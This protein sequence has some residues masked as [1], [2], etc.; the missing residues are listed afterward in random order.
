MAYVGMTYIGMAYVR[1]AYEVVAC[2]RINPQVQKALSPYVLDWNGLYRNGLYR[3]GLCYLWPMKI[4]PAYSLI[5][6][7]RRTCIVMAY[8]VLAYIVMAYMGMAHRGMAYLLMAHVLP[9]DEVM[10]YVLINP[11]V[12]KDL[13]RT[14]PDLADFMHHSYG[15]ILVMAT[16]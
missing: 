10:A 8:I 5:R 1:M 2:M 3:Y 14:F 7:Y 6:R 4:W 13:P 11:Q 9:A 15:N 12:Q 16:Y